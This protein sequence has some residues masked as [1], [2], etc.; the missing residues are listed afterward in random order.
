MNGKNKMPKKSYRF[1]EKQNYKNRK[2]QYTFGK[3]A[4][5]WR[6]SLFDN[7]LERPI[8]TLQFPLEHD[9][10]P[11]NVINSACTTFEKVRGFG[12]ISLQRFVNALVLSGF[13]LFSNESKAKEFAGGTL[14]SGAIAFDETAIYG[15]ENALHNVLN[16]S[17]QMQMTYAHVKDNEYYDYTKDKETQ[18]LEKSEKPISPA[19]AISEVNALSNIFGKT[20]KLWQTQNA[21]YIQK[22]YNIPDSKAYIIKPIQDIAIGLAQ[23]SFL[24]KGHYADYRKVIQGNIDSW[25]SNY[26][27]RLE[28][29]KNVLNNPKLTEELKNIKQKV[30]FFEENNILKQESLDIPKDEILSFIDGL[31]H[32]IP[33]TSG[34][35]KGMDKTPDE[36]DFE[37]ISIFSESLS[38]LYGMVKTINNNIEQYNKERGLKGKNAIAKMPNVSFRK[39]DKVPQFRGSELFNAENYKTETKQH[40]QDLLNATE[41]HFNDLNPNTQDIISILKERD[42][43]RYPNADINNDFVLRNIFHRFIGN[44][45]SMSY[46]TKICFIQYAFDNAW[47][48]NKRDINKYLL[49]RIGAFWRSPKSTSR[50]ES[51]KS[52]NCDVFTLDKIQDFLEYYKANY[53]WNEKY[54]F[55]YL[56]LDFSYKTLCISG[57]DGQIP[58]DKAKP[59]IK[60]DIIRLSP[61][62]STILNNHMVNSNIAQKVFSAYGAKL[63]GMIFTLSRKQFIEK[64]TLRR[65]GDEFLH[66]MPKDKDWIL[67]SHIWNTDNPIKKALAELGFDNVQSVHSYD[68]FDRIQAQKKS[69]ENANIRALLK[70]LPHDWG[71]YIKDAENTEY[72]KKYNKSL[73]LKKN[74]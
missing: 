64:I 11:E 49:N 1:N 42:K 61:I 22:Y 74:T 51:Y 48:H 30:P 62:L 55:E 2:L 73:Q 17:V 71:Y 6:S 7:C 43:K 57:L 23:D 35:L 56:Q 50:H 32:A 19:K 54:Y 52:L 34:L 8:R 67:P 21:Q 47:I 27:K 53:M 12:D 72:T 36:A 66:Y 68:V 45:R 13:R 31:I 4:R 58:S 26:S 9:I 16:S 15:G 63:R 40:F 33:K 28:E 38:L 14:E 5:D 37:E 24:T 3:T 20:L 65:V 39:L 44:M 18:K 46:E 60:S 70:Q 41:Q 69:Y 10:L 25:I 29:L 59:R